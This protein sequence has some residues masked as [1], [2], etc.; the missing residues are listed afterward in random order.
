M[1]TVLAEANSDDRAFAIA[2]QNPLLSGRTRYEIIDPTT[3]FPSISLA[4]S[5]AED[6]FG[7][8]PQADKVYIAGEKTNTVWAIR[9]LAEHGV[10]CLLFFGLMRV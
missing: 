4:R 3:T 5:R 10:R 6:M 1:F 9:V 2:Q 8:Q 7:V